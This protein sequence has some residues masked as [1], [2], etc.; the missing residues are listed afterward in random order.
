MIVILLMSVVLISRRKRPVT[1]T[2]STATSH[3]SQDD[4]TSTQHLDTGKLTK[5]SKVSPDGSSKVLLSWLESLPKS[6]S[7]SLE[8]MSPPSPPASHNNSLDSGANTI[9]RRN[10]TLTRTNPYRH[11][12]LTNGSFVSLKDIPTGSDE[13][14]T[15][16]TASTV[17][18]SNSSD[19]SSGSSYNNVGLTSK[20]LKDPTAASVPGP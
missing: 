16:L 18:D 13:G 5:V 15:R 17:D 2:A 6:E 19:T 11:K 8:P 14:S 9:N 7:D 3:T 20:S 10:Q 1:P 4:N 12:M